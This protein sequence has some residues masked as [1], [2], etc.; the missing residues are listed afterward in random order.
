VR[1]LIEYFVRDRVNGR[2]VF[3]DIDGGTGTTLGLA[4]GGVNIVGV[5][6]SSG[7]GLDEGR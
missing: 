4:R 3:V 7:E 5:G 6:R 1:Y 2:N